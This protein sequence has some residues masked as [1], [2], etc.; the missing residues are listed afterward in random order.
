VEANVQLVPACLDLKLAYTNLRAR[1]LSTGLV[2]ARR[3]EHI[4]SLALDFT[5]TPQWLIEPR[6]VLVSKRFSGTGETLPLAPYARTDLYASY[7][8]DRIWKV[9]ARGENIF[10]VRYQE[11]AGF[12]TTGMA[13][14]GGVDATW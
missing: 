14:Y 12:G 13:F 11:V 10:D 6:V 5:P 2:L 7:T 4:L 3:P 1:D 9:F 8:V